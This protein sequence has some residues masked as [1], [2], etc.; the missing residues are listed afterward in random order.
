MRSIGQSPATVIVAIPA[1][2]EAE[3]IE[4][5]L[6]ALSEQRSLDGTTLPPGTFSVILYVN[7]STDGTDAVARSLIGTLPYDLDILKVWLDDADASAGGAR[8][9]AMAEAAR[10]LEAVAGNG[11][12]MT[13]DADTVVPPEWIAHAISI[14]GNGVDAVTGGLVL[15]AADEARLPVHLKARGALEARYGGLLCELESRFDPQDYD[16]WPRHADEPGASLALTLASFKAIKGVPRQA[17]GEDKALCNAL[18]REGF[19]IRHAP[20]LSVTTSGRLT[21]RACGGC[22]DTM[23]QRIVHPNS[24]CDDRLEPIWSAI[25]R[26]YWQGAGEKSTPPGRGLRPRQLPLH[27][28][29]AQIVLAVLGLIHARNVGQP[30]RNMPAPKMSF[31]VNPHASAAFKET[32]ETV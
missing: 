3:R 8:R 23:R 22:A 1:H 27:I 28:L 12:L 7:N 25:A 29:L 11:I 15:D 31:D 14:I 16:P 20:E 4:A 32:A 13:T 9:L 10:R 24:P 5:C 2:N 6:R 26:Y 19:R 17:L 18:R 30:Q 21:G